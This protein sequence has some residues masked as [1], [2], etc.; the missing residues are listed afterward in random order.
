M[1]NYL[2]DHVGTGT[3]TVTLGQFEQVADSHIINPDGADFSAALRDS[4]SAV[5]GFFD[6][7]AEGA[8]TR[9]G[10]TNWLRAVSADTSKAQEAF[11]QIDVDD[12]ACVGVNQQCLGRARRGGSRSARLRAVPPT[13]SPLVRVRRDP[14]EGTRLVG[15]SDPIARVLA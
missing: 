12:D 15:A 7:D 13:I 11:R 8:V 1:R 6:R 5:A 9:E 3:R 4:V 2:A 14:H 10:R